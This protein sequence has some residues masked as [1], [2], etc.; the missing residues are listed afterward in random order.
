MVLTFN[1]GDIFPSRLLHDFK[2]ECVY[3]QRK[4]KETEYR[5]QKLKLKL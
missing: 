3:L 4:K 1:R 2:L 5:I